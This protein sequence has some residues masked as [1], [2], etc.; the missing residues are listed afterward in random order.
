MSRRRQ[1]LCPTPSKRS[2][3][4]L[5]LARASFQQESHQHGRRVVA[6]FAYLCMCRRWHRASSRYTLQGRVRPD[7][8]D[9]AL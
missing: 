2:W 9:L 6:P 4:S 8:V 1:A 3:P 7:C 5:D